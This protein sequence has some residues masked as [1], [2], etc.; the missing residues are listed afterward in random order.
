MSMV[1]PTSSQIEDLLA[2]GYTEAEVSVLS[3]QP[4]IAPVR[5]ATS[6]APSAARTEDISTDRGNLHSSSDNDDDGGS[7]SQFPFM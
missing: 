5:V 2:A 6:A 3:A 7:V 1:V 4:A